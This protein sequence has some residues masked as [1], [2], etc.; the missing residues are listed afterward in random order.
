MF[1]SRRYRVDNEQVVLLLTILLVLAVI[2]LTS[3][4]TF[5]LSGIFIL[6]MFIISALMIRSHHQSLMRQ[7]LSVNKSNTPELS[8]LVE[9]C[10]LK[11]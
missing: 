6:G 1:R 9:N 7:T 4:A 11:L 3:T 8:N 10:A 2:I 5:C